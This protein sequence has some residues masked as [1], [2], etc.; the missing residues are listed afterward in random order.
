MAKKFYYDTVGL[1]DATITAGTYNSSTN[2]FSVAAGEVTNEHYINDQS[3]G[4]AVTSFEVGDMI[5]IS[6]SAAQTASDILYYNNGSK[7]FDDLFIY[8]GANAT[9]SMGLKSEIEI[10]LAGWTANTLTSSS[11]SQYWFLRSEDGTLSGIS[12]VILGVPLTFENEPDI[13]S[14]TQE[15]FATDINT[16][17]GGVEYA[18]KRHEAQ[19]TWTLSFKN[20][21]ETFKNNL[22]SMQDIVQNYQKFVYYDGTA[23]NYVRLDSAI[24]FTEVAYQ[25]YSTSI[26]L[27]EQLS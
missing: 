14:S 3:I 20:I 2:V 21:S 12:E 11:N 13:G 25:R 5:R 24:N 26:K 7:D 27:R 9:G 16:S 23:Y 15:R 22:L 17:L 1:L 10:T 19:S 4:H 18:N 6:L 8:A